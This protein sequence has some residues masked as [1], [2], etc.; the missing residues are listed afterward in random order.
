MGEPVEIFPW[1]QNFETGI[2]AIDEQHRKLVD[3]LNVLVSHL[4]YQSGAP[5]LTKVFKEL[6]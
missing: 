5:A 2:P 3:L 4:A 1:N 6:R